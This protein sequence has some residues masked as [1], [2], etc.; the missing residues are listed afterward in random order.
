MTL[1][2]KTVPDDLL[3]RIGRNVLVYQQIEIALKAIV[4]FIHPKGGA[5]GLDGLQK[6]RQIYSD[7]NLGKLERILV[8]ASEFNVQ[9]F[10][11]YLN[12]VV[13][14]RNELVH[15][16]LQDPRCRLLSEEN[17]ELVRRDLDSQF[18]DAVCFRTI[19]TQLFDEL[20]KHFDSDGKALPGVGAQRK[21][22][23][24]TVRRR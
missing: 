12:R 6:V 9:E 21:V 17:Q 19:V 23:Q 18:E 11:E 20:A 16:F 10:V 8:R 1:T 22:I 7:A 15:N 14:S 5:A 24:A 3:V 13:R 2:A 4:P